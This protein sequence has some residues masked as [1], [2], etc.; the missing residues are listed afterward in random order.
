MYQS[1][2]WQLLHMTSCAELTTLVRKKGRPF[3]YCLVCNLKN[4]F[5]YF[6][7]YLIFY[8]WIGNAYQYVHKIMQML[9]T[10]RLTNTLVFC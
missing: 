1:R 2:N 7:N 10:N 9:L 3:D 5:I 6:Y 8:T 4:T